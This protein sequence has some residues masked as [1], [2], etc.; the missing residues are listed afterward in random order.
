MVELPVGNEA[1][2]IEYNLSSI[3]MSDNTV[4]NVNEKVDINVLKERPSVVNFS[5]EEIKSIDSSKIS[6]KLD[7]EDNDKALLNEMAWLYIYNDKGKVIKSR[8]IFANEENIKVKLGEE[9]DPIRDLKIKAL[10]VDGTDIT[11]KVVIEENN[12]DVSILGEYIVKVLVI[13]KN[14]EEIRKEFIVEVTDSILNRILGRNIADNKNKSID[15]KNDSISYSGIYLSD[16]KK[17]TITVSGK[18][19]QVFQPDVIINGEVL[20]GNGGAPSGK[21][22]VELPMRVNFTVDKDGKFIGTNFDVKNNGGC[23]IKLSLESFTEEDPIGGIIIN[24]NLKDFES[25]GRA[26]IALGLKATSN[27]D[28]VTTKLDETVSN[29]ELATIGEGKSATIHILGKAGTGKSNEEDT[30][31]ATE[32]F[33]LRFR[34]KKA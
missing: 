1:G 17:S 25:V 21:I 15:F 8:I 28:I 32:T 16:D 5:Y 26:T 7:L 24:N 33:T 20:K 19:D 34:I 30:N 29:K 11:E 10:D 3:R 13:N 14:N 23:D 9:F 6:I 27:G 31:G 12:V 18:D 4:I 22:E 2:I